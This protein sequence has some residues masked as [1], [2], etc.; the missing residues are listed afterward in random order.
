MKLIEL[1]AAALFC[2]LAVSGAQAQVSAPETGY[3]TPRLFLEQ[4]PQ[5]HLSGTAM[6]GIRAELALPEEA[7]DITTL[8]AVR[9]WLEDTFDSAALGGAT[10]GQTTAAGLLKERRLGGCHDWALMYASVLRGLGYPARLADAASL[11]WA[12]E[13]KTATSVSGHVFV[14]VYA[15][16]KWLLVDPVTGRLILDYDPAEPVIPLYLDREPAG[17]Y[18]VLKGAD[19]AAYGVAEIGG[20]HAALKDFAEKLPGLKLNFP[21]YS[22][23]SL[24]RSAPPPLKVAEAAVSEPCAASP[25]AGRAKAG[26]VLQAGGFDL[27]LEKQ[28]NAYK[29]H[30]YPYGRVFGAAELKTLSF[31]T[32]RELNAHLRTLSAP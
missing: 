27:H 24:A 25:C 5:S 19:P 23:V 13:F 31:G 4:G 29:A 10:V 30:Y 9:F 6:E 7:G 20:L 1:T 17:F 8:S 32:L 2:C 28:G 14:E 11:R 21:R 26:L 3:S 22:V 12:R 15:A 16:G 18:A